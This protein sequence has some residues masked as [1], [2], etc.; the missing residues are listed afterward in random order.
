MALT[1]RLRPASSADAEALAAIEQESFPDPSW[2]SDDFLKYD[3]VVAEVGLIPSI[4]GF[5]V[6]RETFPGTAEA[7]A[8]REI[9]NLAVAVQFRRLGIARAL[10]ENELKRAAEVFLEVRR[11]NAPAIQLYKTAGF[12][13]VS[14]RCAYYDNPVESAIVMRT[15]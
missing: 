14:Q 11:S 1:I 12:I 4:G 6:S 10:L 7:P 9:L 5:L 3:C 8:E 13:E 2:T 15:K